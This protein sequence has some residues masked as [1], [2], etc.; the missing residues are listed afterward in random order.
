M[1]LKSRLTRFLTV[2]GACLIV[3]KDHLA[4]GAVGCEPV[5]EVILVLLQTLGNTEAIKCA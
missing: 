5:F 4:L 1:L 2:S 3:V